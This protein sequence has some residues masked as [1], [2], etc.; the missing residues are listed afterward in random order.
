LRFFFYG[1]L[2]DA[3]VRRLVLGRLAPDE[4]EPA[5]LN[6]WRR[7]KLAG[8]TYPGIVVDPKGTVEG[9]LARD[10]GTA[11][12]RALVRY[13]GDEYELVPAE[14]AT[15]EGKTVGAL[16]FVSGRALKRASGVWGIA[17]WQRRHKRRFLASLSRSGSPS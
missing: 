4:V 6:G 9:V 16:M 15:A 2:I 8:V 5:I 11:A 17:D 3:D 12:K 7:V 1:T 10:L 13:E 14:V